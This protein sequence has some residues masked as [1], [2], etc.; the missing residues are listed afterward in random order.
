MSKCAR[1]RKNS[2]AAARAPARD[3]VDLARSVHYLPEH[4]ALV[5]TPQ[6]VCRRRASLGGGAERFAKEL[7]EGKKSG[8]RGC[9]T[10]RRGSLTAAAAR[11][12]GGCPSALACEEESPVAPG[13]T[14]SR[15]APRSLGAGADRQGWRA[16]S[17]GGR[18]DHHGHRGVGRPIRGGDLCAAG[19]EKAHAFEARLRPA[20]LLAPQ[21]RNDVPKEAGQLCAG[22]LVKQSP[23][24]TVSLM[25]VCRPCAQLL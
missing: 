7:E 9:A 2:I 18:A 15:H 22:A 23:L 20:A 5:A 6:G 8:A 17:A 11:A 25:G 24:L 13:S 10:G 1:N 16:G 12:Q 4:A 3:R 19:R 21:D 14:A